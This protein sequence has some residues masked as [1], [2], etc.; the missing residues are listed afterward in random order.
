MGFDTYGA[1]RAAA[2]LIGTDGINQSMLPMNTTKSMWTMQIQ[3]VYSLIYPW[4][5]MNYGN[6]DET[7]MAIK[8]AFITH[9]T[10]NMHGGLF[11]S[12]GSTAVMDIPLIPRERLFS[13]GMTPSKSTN[14]E[15]QTAAT[16]ES[17]NT[18]VLVKADS[19]IVSYGV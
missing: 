9:D 18:S 13:T 8:L 1:G 19:P 16:M 4:L 14:L 11:S 10:T 3:G 5:H 2:T 6:R 17:A 7:N 15:R 12:P